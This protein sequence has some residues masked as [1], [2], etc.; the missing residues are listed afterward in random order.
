[1]DIESI[2]STWRSIS[3]SKADSGADSGKVSSDAARAA[4]AEALV[5]KLKKQQ[6]NTY[7][8]RIRNKFLRSGWLGVL[9]PVLFVPML[10][11]LKMSVALMVVYGLTLVALGLLNLWLARRVKNTE[12]V[13]LPVVDATREILKLR[14]L[15]VKMRIYGVLCSIPALAMFFMELSEVGDGYLVL[16]GVTGAVI[17][18]L[19]GWIAIHRI[20]RNFRKI[21]EIL[22]LDAPE[23]IDV[24]D[25][26]GA[27]TV[28]KTNNAPGAD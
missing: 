1:M 18:G 13:S 25:T 2:Q 20:N 21:H 15:I 19:I 3:E 11:K 26:P 9:S 14:R 10:C 6:I 5:A 8:Q 12:I 22:T 7:S 17:G 16:S 4:A 28:T 24:P 27:N 23:S